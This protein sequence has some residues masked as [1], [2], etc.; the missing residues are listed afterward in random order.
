M[1]YD[2]FKFNLK[3][4]SKELSDEK[5]HTKN[6]ELKQF[7]ALKNKKPKIQGV[8]QIEREGNNTLDTLAAIQVLNFLNEFGFD[9]KHLNASPSKKVEIPKCLNL[10]KVFSRTFKRRGFLLGYRG[11]ESQW[12]ID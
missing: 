12:E 4:S 1:V 2:K 10:I 6:E 8:D 9:G 7:L 5:G 3:T 11:S